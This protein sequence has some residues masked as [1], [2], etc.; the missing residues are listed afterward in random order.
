MLIRIYKQTRKWIC[1]LQN[2]LL[3]LESI[4]VLE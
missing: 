4:Y 3:L 1:K 2:G